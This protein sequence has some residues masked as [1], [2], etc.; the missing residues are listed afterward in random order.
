MLTQAALQKNKK[1]PT[2]NGMGNLATN[3]TGFPQWKQCDHVNV[4]FIVG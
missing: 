2:H 4:I 3:G 1:M